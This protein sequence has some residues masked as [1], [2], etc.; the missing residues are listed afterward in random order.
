MS[1]LDIDYRQVVCQDYFLRLAHKVNVQQLVE[2]FNRLRFKACQQGIQARTEAIVFITRH[3]DTLAVLEDLDC[4]QE[5]SRE[6]LN[7]LVCRLYDI[8]TDAY[9]AY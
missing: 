1:I 4:E 7:R 6:L 9:A 8:R 2:D 3:L 5:E